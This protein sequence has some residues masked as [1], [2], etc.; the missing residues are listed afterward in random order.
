MAF[1]FLLVYYRNIILPIRAVFPL[2]GTLYIV[3]FIMTTFFNKKF[4][5]GEVFFLAGDAIQF[6]QAHFNDL[7]AGCYMFSTRAKYRTDQVGIF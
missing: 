2:V 7:M 1:C 5:S 4:C 3:A 6:Y